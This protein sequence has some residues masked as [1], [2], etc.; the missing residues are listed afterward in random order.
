MLGNWEH[1]EE[2]SIQVLW[3]AHEIKKET[4]LDFQFYTSR[5]VEN[6]MKQNR[7]MNDETMK[8]KC[9]TVVESQ[10][11]SAL[12]IPILNSPAM[13]PIP[14]EIKTLL[15]LNHLF[16]RINFYFHFLYSFTFNLPI[17]KEDSFA[18]TFHQYP[19]TI[20]FNLNLKFSMRKY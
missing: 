10:N 14:N 5:K 20:D 11:D 18:G 4:L 3:A 8:Q 6:E 17:P 15:K 7:N 12:F 2:L 1:L 13:S 9:T 19:L 16:Y